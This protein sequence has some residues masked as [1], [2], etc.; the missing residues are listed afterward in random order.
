MRAEVLDIREEGWY[1]FQD[2]FQHC[3]LLSQFFP[4]L[5]LKP[6]ALLAQLAARCSPS[7]SRA[8]FVTTKT[9]SQLKLCL[10]GLSF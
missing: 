10:P 3:L 4:A 8:S 9:F 5:F 6:A 7:W 1:S 2:R